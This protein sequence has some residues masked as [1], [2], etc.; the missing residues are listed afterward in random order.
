M[1]YALFPGC[2]SKGATP[3]LYTST[4]KVVG[5]L[6]LDIV[7]LEAFNCCGA[8]VISEADPDLAYTLNAR[9]LATAEKMGIN[10]IMTICG[11]CQGILGGANKNLQEDDALRD[12]IN[13]ALKDTTGLEY[14]GTVEVKH[15]QW[16]LIKDFGL[17]ELGKF[18]THP[19]NVSIAPFYG[20]YILRPSRATGFDDWENPTSLEK[21]I[22]AVGAYPVE[23][24]GRTKCCGFPVLLEKDQIAL[25]MVAK[26]VGEAKEKGSDAMVT[27]CPLC[28]MSLDIYQDHAEDRLQQTRPDE[29]LGVPILHLP[30]LLGLAMG[31]SP[32]EL[33][34]KR[35]LVSTAPLI[36]KIQ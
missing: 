23:Y 20:C 9:T 5:R 36:E 28:H 15:L 34:M 14:R 3:E 13:R 1:K 6:G 29:T 19:L 31:F 16:I 18:I 7:E 4:M 21:L 25:S 35:H 8:G 2:A 11:T 12:R 26:N 33:G 27:P 22:R 30:Q 24:D 17:D 10:N 32:K